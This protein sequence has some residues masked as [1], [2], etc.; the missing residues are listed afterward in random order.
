MIRLLKNYS[1]PGAP[2]SELQLQPAGFDL[3]AAAVS[4]FCGNGT[5][6]FT[7]A[8]RALPDLEELAWPSG[9]DGLLLTPGAYLIT[10]N[11]E[12]AV[13]A[14]C[15]GIVLPRSS[16][17]RCGAVLHS[18]LWDPGYRGRGQ[19]LLSVNVPLRLHESARIGQFVLIAL[20]TATE[21]LYQ[22]VYQLENL[23]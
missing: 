6:D 11:E 3:S 20:E 13:P 7:N 12:I 10:Y 18:A 8:R 23:H 16:L 9:E 19:G 5:L 17:M 15:A 22:G 1:F 4:R 21:R 14:D 2:N